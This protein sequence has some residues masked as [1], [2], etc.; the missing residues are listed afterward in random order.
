MKIFDT[1]VHYPVSFFQ[2][3]NINIKTAEKNLYNLIETF[4]RINIVKACLIGGPGIINDLTADAI[5]KYSN[6]FIGLAFLDLDESKPDH[7]KKFKQLGFRGLKLI[8]PKKNYDD[9]AYFPLY[10]EAEKQ[11]MVCLFH[12]GILGGIEDYLKE[13]SGTSPALINDV[14]KFESILKKTGT[15]S[16]KMQPITLDTIGTLFPELKIIGAHVGYG[17][18]DVAAA[19]ARWRRNVSFDISGGD[20]VRRHIIEGN[21]IKK[22]INVKRLLFGSDS[23]TER[24]ENEILDWIREFDKI[25]L[26]EEEKNNIFYNNAAKIFEE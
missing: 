20:V 23:K 6:L 15:S 12:T 1:H 3:E 24:V 17:M 10:D 19:V 2:S 11:G 9:E 21:Y 14:K 4:N 18:Y 13:E 26:T 16:A 22:E 7:I 8:C 5:K 25:G